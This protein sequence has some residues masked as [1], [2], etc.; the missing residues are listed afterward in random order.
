MTGGNARSQLERIAHA[1]MLEAGLLPDFSPD[2]IAQASAIRGPAPITADV[3]DLLSVADV[4]MPGVAKILVAIAD[5]DALVTRGTPI[6]SHA[7]ANTTSV[8]TA[9]QI[10]PMLPEKLSTDLTSLADHAERLAIVIEMAISAEGA[11]TSSQV[12]RAAVVN[13]AKLAYNSTAAWL[14]GTA[15]APAP[16][17]AVPGMDEQ[18]RIQDRVAQS[19]R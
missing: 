5:V 19:L 11:I 3:L 1:A 16:V 13:R 14:E 2:V 10:F 18:L 7:Q 15:P 17:T 4:S 12:Y 9:A 8:Y 6:D